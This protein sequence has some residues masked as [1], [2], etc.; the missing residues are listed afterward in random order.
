M[1]LRST[2]G[3]RPHDASFANRLGSQ[4]LRRRWGRGFGLIRVPV[5]SSLRSSPTCPWPPSLPGWRVFVTGPGGDG[6]AVLATQAAGP[7]PRAEVPRDRYALR[8]LLGK[9][10]EALKTCETPGMNNKM[11]S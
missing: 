1:P 7:D 4:R 8:E 2:Q 5:V 9:V 6:P 10:Q 3:W 11:G